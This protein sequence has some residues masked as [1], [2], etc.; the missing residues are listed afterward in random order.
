MSI[1]CHSAL[2]TDSLFPV[3]L[4]QS[5][6]IGIGQTDDA[7]YQNGRKIIYVSQDNYFIADLA[8]NEDITYY[9]D[10]ATSCIVIISTGYSEQLN[11]NIAV[12]SHLSRP[13]RFQKYFAIVERLLSKDVCIYA[14]GANP[15]FP[16]KKLD[17]SY[18]DTAHR[19]AL[20][21]TQWISSG[22]IQ[23][24]QISLNLGQGIPSVYNNNL[25]CYSLTCD[26]NGNISVNNDRVYLT[27]EQRDPSGGL[28]TLF[29]MYGDPNEIRRQDLEFTDGEIK[30]LVDAAH[31]KNLEQVVDM[32]DEEILKTY[33]STPDYEVPWFCDSI[34]Q[35]GIFVKNYMEKESN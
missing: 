17:G 24:K 33:S 8:S 35:A 34:R 6:D 4:D 13:G 23:T 22:Q 21:V 25:D 31:D 7:I 30:V 27:E 11:K 29:C 28:Q 15:P 32:E 1:L 3:T 20:Q 16:C 19:N 5:P 9:C 26:K 2:S 14:S 12:I 10:S 18:D